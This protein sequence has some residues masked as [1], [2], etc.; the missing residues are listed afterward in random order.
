MSERRRGAPYSLKSASTATGS[1][2]EMMEPKMSET[3]NGISI[4]IQVK[5][6]SMPSAIRSADTMRLI[7]ERIL[8][9]GAS[10]L[11]CLI[12]ILNADSKMSVGRNI[13]KRSSGVRV[14]SLKKWSG[15][16]KESAPRMTPI[17]TRSTVC[18]IFMRC[19][20]KSEILDIAS[21]RKS[22]SADSAVS[23]VRA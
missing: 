3:M 20:M 18:G 15:G 19:A 7:T 23:M 22:A 8:M 1:V 10:S 11:K 6:Q 9:I 16:R 5:T 14:N 17:P 2:A 13:K 12:G 4:P 21:M